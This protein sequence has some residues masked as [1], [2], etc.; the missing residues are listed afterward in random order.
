MVATSS[1]NAALDRGRYLGTTRRPCN[2]ELVHD[3]KSCWA[4]CENHHYL[5]PVRQSV[6][7][8]DADGDLHERQEH[9]RW[10]K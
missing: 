7:E 8:A 3:G 10:Q 4:V 9:A 6:A 5:G 2:A 1:R